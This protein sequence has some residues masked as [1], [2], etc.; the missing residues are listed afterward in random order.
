MADWATDHHDV[1]V[2]LLTPLGVGPPPN[3][4][5]LDETDP[6][7]FTGWVAV[8][9]SRLVTFGPELSWLRAHCNSDTIGRS[10]LVYRFDEPPSRAPGPP[11]ASCTDQ[12]TS[13]R[14]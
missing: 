1:A 6:D 12:D 4:D 13:T 9:V 2:S 5:P 3:T 8:S 14:R 7:T 10:V 11:V